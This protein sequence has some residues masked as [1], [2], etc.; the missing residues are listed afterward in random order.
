MDPRKLKHILENRQDL[1]VMNAFN[2]EQLKHLRESVYEH[3]PNAE[4]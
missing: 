3:P 1:G 4:Y 2:A